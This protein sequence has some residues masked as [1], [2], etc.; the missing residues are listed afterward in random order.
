MADADL[1]ELERAFKA[2][3]TN[4]K[5]WGALDA[6]RKRLLSPR[7]RLLLEIRDRPEEHRHDF[8]GLVA[9]A[10]RPDG[11]SVDVGIMEAHE[12]AG[13]DVA[14]GPCS[15]GAFHRR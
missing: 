10:M 15:C 2:D 9:C 1:R 4:E 3:P 8:P 5:A 14:D 6:A 7:E 13:C 11:Y 12:S